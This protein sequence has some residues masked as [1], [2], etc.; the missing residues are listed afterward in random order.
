M[1]LAIVAALA[2]LAL[3]AAAQDATPRYAIDLTIVEN[4]VEVTSARTLIVEGGQANV[5]L[6]GADGQHSFDANLQPEQGDGEDDKLVLELYLNHDGQTLASPTMIMKRGGS[7]QMRIGSEGPDR[8]LTDGIEIEVR[9]L[10][11]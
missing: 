6:T 4:G 8:A 10:R 9:P 1:R 5:V 7:A 2:T 11:P 3:P